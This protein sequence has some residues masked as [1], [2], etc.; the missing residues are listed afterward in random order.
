[1]VALP[2][3]PHI[4]SFAANSVPS[5]AEFHSDFRCLFSRFLDDCNAHFLHGSAVSSDTWQRHRDNRHSLANPISG[6][7][8]VVPDSITGSFKFR[9]ERQRE[10]PIQ[11]LRPSGI[12]HCQVHDQPHHCNG[13]LNQMKN[14][15]DQTIC[16]FSMQLCDTQVERPS[17]FPSLDAVDIFAEFRG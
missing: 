14:D 6:S 15:L 7:A 17:D 5:R 3:Q 13:S 9:T 2:G 16:N 12:Y 1:V 10:Q 8:A 11:G 4:L